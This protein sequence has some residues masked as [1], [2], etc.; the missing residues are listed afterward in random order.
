MKH[1]TEENPLTH[2]NGFIEVARSHHVSLLT[3][4]IL[5]LLAPEFLSNGIWKLGVACS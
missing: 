5:K 3:S 2:S 4:T 1:G